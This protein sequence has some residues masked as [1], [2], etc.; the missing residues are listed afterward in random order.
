MQ[1]TLQDDDAVAARNSDTFASSW[2]KVNYYPLLVLFP[3]S[4]GSRQWGSYTSLVHITS[5][6]MIARKLQWQ[7]AWVSW[8][9]IL[10]QW[11]S[12]NVSTNDVQLLHHLRP[13]KLELMVQIQ[14]NTVCAPELVQIGHGFDIILYYIICVAWWVIN[15]FWHLCNCCLISCSID[16][17]NTSH[18]EQIR[19]EHW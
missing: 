9:H 2:S 7:N 1:S 3:T 10:V 14:V 5:A 15:A 19:S 12:Y 18:S 17:H 11:S 16:S 4:R 6:L 13:E 8:C